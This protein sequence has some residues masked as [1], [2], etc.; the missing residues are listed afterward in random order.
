MEFSFIGYC[1]D[2]DVQADSMV[3]FAPDAMDKEAQG[4][5]MVDASTIY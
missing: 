1:M 2:Q 5:N 4:D 3:A